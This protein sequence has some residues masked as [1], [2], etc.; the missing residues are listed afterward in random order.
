[1]FDFN[2][3]KYEKEIVEKKIIKGNIRTIFSIRTNHIILITSMILW[4]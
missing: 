4:K 3:N 1:M 2:Y